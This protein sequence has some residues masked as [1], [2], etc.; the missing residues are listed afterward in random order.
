MNNI[1]LKTLMFLACGLVGIHTC[2]TASVQVIGSLVRNRS[3]RPGDTFEGMVLLRNMGN[4][5]AEVRMSQ[6][7]YLFYADG[8]DLYGEPGTTP[9][10]NAR[11]ISVAPSQV[12]IP[13]HETAGVSYRVSVPTQDNLAGTYWS[14]LMIEPAATPLAPVTNQ[15]V[16][17]RVQTVVRFGVQIVTE[18]GDGGNG[19]LRVTNK[20]LS[21]D[22]PK[23]RFLLCPPSAK[24]RHG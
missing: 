10:S 15:E 20:R 14:M 9:R 19:T 18:V 13:P 21:T 7:D 11:W 8:R 5:P 3:V 1:R 16:V 24:L 22:G 23:R 4:E 2:A 12:T 17:V 6:T